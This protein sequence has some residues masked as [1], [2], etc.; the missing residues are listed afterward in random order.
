MGRA[1]DPHRQFRKALENH[2]FDDALLLAR[3]LPVSDAEA[4]TLTIIGGETRVPL[5][6]PM[7]LRWVSNLID[8]RKI[9]SLEQLAWIM[10][11]FNQVRRGQAIPAEQALQRFIASA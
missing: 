11:R 6:E 1:S 9:R 3:D 8:D 7:A 10:E 5:Y 4:L 2:V